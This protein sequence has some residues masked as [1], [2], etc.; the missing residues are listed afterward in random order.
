MTVVVDLEP[1]VRECTAEEAE[2]L[3]A[4]TMAASGE[5]SVRMAMFLELVGQFD[6]TN[7]V[8]FWA[9]IDSTAH[10]VAWA[11]S[12]APV[13]SREYVRIARALRRMPH[14]RARFATGELSYS[15]VREMTRLVDRIDPSDSADPSDPSSWG[16]EAS[17]QVTDDRAPAA[18][19]PHLETGWDSRP[20][21][22]QRLIDFARQT[23]A[24]QLGRTLR[25]YRAA[26]GTAEEQ[27]TRHRVSWWTDEAGNLHLSA[28]LPAEAG[29]A[30][31]TALQAAIDANRPPDAQCGDV[32]PDDDQPDHDQHG[33]RRYV[34]D[35]RREAVQRTR[36]E[37]MSEIS[38]HYLASRP[39]DRS[40]E[41][42]TLVVLEINATALQT[43][44]GDQPTVA[45]EGSADRT[46][47]ADGAS[48]EAD[49]PP[50]T[51][52]DASAEAPTPT[53]RVRGGGAIDPATAHR[54]LCDARI[55]GII[56]NNLGEPLAVGRS[57]RLVTRAQRR[58]LAIRDGCCQYPGC[59]RTRRLQAHHRTSWLAGGNTDLENLI[60]LCPWHHTVVHE[61]KITI[62]GCDEPTCTVRWRFTR[63]DRT[64]IIPTVH[65]LGAPSPW[66]PILDAEGRAPTGRAWDNAARDRDR[67]MAE[68]QTEQAALCE[69]QEELRRRYGHITHTNH[70]DAHRVFPPGGGEGFNLAN[71]VEVLF[72][73]TA[74]NNTDLAA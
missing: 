48:A 63:P 5:V 29:A 45:A 1:G 10:W 13:T 44:G 52:D 15:K 50:G 59:P 36:V 25:G 4:Q 41:D 18:D 32:E 9:G 61:H 49:T 22:E 43:D 39:E 72:N 34:D 67:Q 60:L 68:Y 71:C 33:R 70:P 66:Q 57:Q 58:A 35:E 42:R 40:G 8:R 56:I 38:T 73:I 14:T 64:P 69:Q 24:S 3:A 6:A 11:C 7:A 74:R 20:D 37:A 53:C 55:L 28:V 30:V 31:T 46:T 17:D 51:I 16:V 12:I 54:T 23:T 47:S 27:R 62:T 21:A 2:A 65:D 19:E 26:A